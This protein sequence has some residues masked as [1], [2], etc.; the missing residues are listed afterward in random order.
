MNRLGKYKDEQVKFVILHG[1]RIDITLTI[2]NFPK[3]KLK[4]MMVFPFAEDWPGGPVNVATPLEREEDGIKK[5]SPMN[6]SE[7]F[8]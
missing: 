1:K 2:S 6:L 5:G 4:Q 8:P 7:R 3:W